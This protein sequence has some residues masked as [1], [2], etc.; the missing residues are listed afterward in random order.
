[1]ITK[2][3]KWDNYKHTIQFTKNTNNMKLLEQTTIGGQAL[4]NR[5]VMAPMTRSRADLNG[6]VSE[7]TVTYY[8]QRSTAGL[9]ISEGVNIS[10]QAI[11][12]GPPAPPATSNNHKKEEK[13]KKKKRG[14]K[15]RKIFFFFW[16]GHQGGG[17]RAPRLP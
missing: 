2:A 12:Q 10:E 13:K 3:V 7:M 4:K 15:K 16:V 1:M 17:G 14:R 9:I 5:I 11:R 6:N 8:R